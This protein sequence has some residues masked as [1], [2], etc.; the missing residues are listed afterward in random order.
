[1]RLLMKVLKNLFGNGTKI[2]VSEIAIKNNENKGISLDDYINI[3]HLDNEIIPTNEFV[4]GKRVYTKRVIIPK[5]PNSTNIE[6]AT[7]LPS[8]GISVVRLDGLYGG[9][10]PIN[11]IFP[12]EINLSIGTYWYAPNKI[13]ITTGSNRSNIGGYVDVYFYYNQ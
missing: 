9:I 5:L 4:K 1:M 11:F 2:S 7:G 8:S 6:Y 13:Q 3:N 12:I 10:F